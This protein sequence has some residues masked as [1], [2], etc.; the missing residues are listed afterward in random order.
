MGWR[1]RECSETHTESF[2][3]CWRC[4]LGRDGQPPAPDPV[5]DP[6]EPE[7]VLSPEE[8]AAERAALRARAAE[9]AYDEA[10]DYDVRLAPLAR[11]ARGWHAYRSRTA[12]DRWGQRPPSPDPTLDRLWSVVVVAF[13]SSIGLWL[14]LIAFPRRVFAVWGEVWLWAMLLTMGVAVL[15]GSYVAGRELRLARRRGSAA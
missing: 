7:V 15:L 9:I 11:L 2:D 4:G 5:E 12:P 13:G 6:D 1:C 8:E 10:L 14:A 3:V